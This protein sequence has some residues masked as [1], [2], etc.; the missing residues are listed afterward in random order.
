MTAYPDETHAGG[1]TLEFF[2]SLGKPFI[3]SELVSA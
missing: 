3:T 1:K 2:N